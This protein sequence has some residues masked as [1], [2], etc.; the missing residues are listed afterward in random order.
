M[1]KYTHE[2]EHKEPMLNPMRLLMTIC[3]WWVQIPLLAVNLLIYPRAFI[4]RSQQVPVSLT[5]ELHLAGFL[6]GSQGLKPLHLY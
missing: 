5:C 2:S 6:R 1:Y 4:T 3:R